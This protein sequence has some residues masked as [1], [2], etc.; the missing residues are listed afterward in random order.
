MP[1]SLFNLPLRINGTQEGG[2]IFFWLISWSCLLSIL[3]VSYVLQ[4]LYFDMGSIMVKMLFISGDHR[5]ERGEKSL[6]AY[7]DGLLLNY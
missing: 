7:Q 1:F 4:R 6:F 3:V 5:F 2:G